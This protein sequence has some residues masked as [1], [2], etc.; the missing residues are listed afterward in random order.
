MTHYSVHKET[1]F[2][3]LLG[4]L[5]L[6]DSLLRHELYLPVFH[7]CA[8]SVK[9][10]M[11]KIALRLASAYPTLFI[12]ILSPC[13]HIPILLFQIYLYS[14]LGLPGGLVVK[15]LH[16]PTPGDTS[17]FSW[18]ELTPG[19]ETKIE[20]HMMQRKKIP[21]KYFSSAEV[22]YDQL[23]CKTIT[24]RVFKRYHKLAKAEV[25]I[26]ALHPSPQHPIASRKWVLPLSPGYSG[27]KPGVN[28]SS[29]HILDPVYELSPASSTV[30]K[31]KLKFDHFSFLLLDS[32]PRSHNP[33]GNTPRTFL[34]I[35]F[36][37]SPY[38]RDHS[39]Q[40]SHSD[41]FKSK[42]MHLQQHGET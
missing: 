6:L 7:R 11:A 19:L 37:Y 9:S 23:T 16:A 40:N 15:R 14:V 8:L 21:S 17:L 10:L 35:C 25:S 1:C 31:I 36:L 30:K 26:T 33:Y 24:A 34:N 4:H 28:D 2:P 20:C 5:T 3:L 42:S 27:C 32:S 18:L 13:C 41:I 29:F 22:R 12:Y 39:P 38:S